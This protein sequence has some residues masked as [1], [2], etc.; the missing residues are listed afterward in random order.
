MA[1]LTA[2]DDWQ[3]KTDALNEEAWAVRV[4]NSA[5]AFELSAEALQL[6]KT[7]HYKKGQAEAL[8]TYGFAHIRLSK[9][10]EAKS[11]LDEALLLF[12][13]LGDERGQS[14]VYEYQGIIYRSLGD[15]D[16]SLRSLYQ[17]LQLRQQTGYKDGTALSYYHLGVTYKYLGNLE[18]ALQYLLQS[19][20]VAREIQN[21]VAESYSLNLVG[22]IYFETADYEQALAYYEQSLQLR[23]SSGDRWGEAGC[24][25]NMGY[26]FCRL[27]DAEKAVQH[28]TQS[29]SIC[30]ST[31]DKKGQANTLFHLGELHRQGGEEEKAVETAQESLRIRREIGDQKGQ[32]E[33]LLFL[34][35]AAGSGEANE[36]ATLLLLTEALAIGNDIKAQ[37]LLAKI[38]FHFYTHYRQKGEYQQA[39]ESFEAFQQL[40][41]KLHK[42]AL[43]E[44]VVNLQITHRVEQ[45][46]MEAENYRMRNDELAA[47]NE[48]LKRQKEETEQQK[49]VA[50]ASLQQLKQ[51]QWQLVQKEKMA[52]LGEL[53]AGIAHE[54]QNPLNFVNNFAE[55]NMDLVT[56]ATELLQQGH[57]EEALDC[58]ATIK[59][60]EEKIAHHGKRADSIVKSMLQHSRTASGTKEPVDINVLAAE[61]LRLSY[62]GFR[63]K[64]K[65]FQA[66][67]ITDFDDAIGTINAAPQDIGRV[68]LN[69]YNNA[70]YSVHQQKK[71]R[72]ETFEPRVEIM[73]RRTGD[74]VQI[75]VSDNGAGIPDAI[76][77]KIF[78]PFFT[79]K[80]TGEGTGLGLSLSYDIIT[81]GHG[82]ELTVDSTRDEGI[83]FT[84]LLPV[85]DSGKSLSVD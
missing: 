39:L 43:A 8:R 33:L 22:Q 52:S 16:A 72:G 15:F 9:N 75:C 29:L 10:R 59:A 28:Y 68:L 85:I 25:D 79:T 5:R 30:R 6:A 70:F 36:D 32:A 4:S 67:L 21:W 76:V 78:Q 38:H 81:K 45:A 2:I 50:E 44:K 35:N 11:L 24:L 65:L 31:G 46:K 60:N 34:A 12:T 27:G 66:K 74:V 41:K 54:I 71:N 23:R 37:D 42:E 1:S 3:Q 64:D 40:E 55:V 48:E 53:I 62:H 69:L 19:L 58:L 83:M 73:T 61:Y 18:K 51:T 26:A 7:H 49:Q 63:A 80:P 57:V 13:E 77:D 82:G 84:I 14:D 17:G 56:E 47:L 20:Q